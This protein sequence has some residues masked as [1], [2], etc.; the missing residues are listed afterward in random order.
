MEGQKNEFGTSFGAFLALLV[1]GYQGG[2]RDGGQFE[3]D[4]EHDEM[5]TGNHEVHAK[6]REEHHGV[7]LAHLDAVFSAVEPL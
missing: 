2:H 5:A 7:E 3:S 6:K 4:E 1:V